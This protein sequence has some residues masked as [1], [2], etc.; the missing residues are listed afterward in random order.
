MKNR[1]RYKISAV[2]RSYL[3]QIYFIVMNN[4]CKNLGGE[5]INVTEVGVRDGF[6][7][8]LMEGEND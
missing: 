7:L 8:K 3:E 2:S 4:I 1:I 6:V 5:R